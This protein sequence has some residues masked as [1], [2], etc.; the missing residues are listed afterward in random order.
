MK[1]ILAAITVAATLI[2]SS[3]SAFDPVHFKRLKETG[4]CWIDC[5]LRGADLRGADLSGAFL[6]NA[7][8]N[9]SDLSNAYLYGS[10]LSNAYLK[11]VILCNTTMPDGSV[12]Y[13]GC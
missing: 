9:R 7:Y 13:T 5:N 8:L 12:L 10:M 11:G 4:V 2:A 3:A 1:R 6:S